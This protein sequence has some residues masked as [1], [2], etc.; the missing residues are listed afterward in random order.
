MKKYYEK[1]GEEYVE[2]H[3]FD[4]IQHRFPPGHYLISSFKNGHNIRTITPDLATATAAGIYS[5]D[6][7]ANAIVKAAAARPTLTPLTKKQIA[8][9]NKMNKAFDSELETL[10]IPSAIDIADA[11]IDAMAKEANKFLTNPAVKKAWDH[12]MLVCKLTQEN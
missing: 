2:V 4:F 7:I 6:V 3:P 10:S 5:R 1:I 9:W 11:G 8:A 12:F